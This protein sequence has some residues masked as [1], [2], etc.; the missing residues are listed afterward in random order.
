MKTYVPSGKDLERQRRWFVVDAAGMTVGR[1]ASRLAP[2]LIG[3]NKPSYTP[4]LDLGDHVI[5]VNAAKVNLTGRKWEQKL[6][7][8]HSGYPGGFK[9]ASAK[10]VLAE[11][12]ERIIQGAVH[13]MLPKSKLGK[14]IGK[15]LKVYAGP[16]HPHS[17]QNPETLKF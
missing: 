10:K 11:R 4:F 14:R 2:I 6:Y 5:V 13:G 15:K 17:A 3:K 12:P 9:Q 1:L 8:H 7:R 16:D